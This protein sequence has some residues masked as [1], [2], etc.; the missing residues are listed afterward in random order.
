MLSRLMSLRT[1]S[2]IPVIVTSVPR[3]VGLIWMDG[4]DVDRQPQQN[5]NKKSEDQFFMII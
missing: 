2:L 3:F 1:A 4:G 5:I